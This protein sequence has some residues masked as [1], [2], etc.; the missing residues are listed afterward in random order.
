MNSISLHDATCLQGD[1][2]TQEVILVGEIVIE[3]RLAG[4]AGL[5]HFIE[6][7]ALRAALIDQSGGGFDD[8][9]FGG[10]SSR[11]QRTS[12]SLEMIGHQGDSQQWT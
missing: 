6:T 11:G 12:L 8:A 10:H 1:H 9:Q 3:L 5:H 2:F 7:H 4:A